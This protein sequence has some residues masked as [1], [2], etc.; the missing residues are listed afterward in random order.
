MSSNVDHIGMR[1]KDITSKFGR[2][3]RRRRQELGFSQERLAELADLLRTYIADIER[4]TRNLSLINI[5]K[6]SRALDLKPAELFEEY[7]EK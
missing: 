5:I 2:G 4:G 6:L 7:Y 3:I 1:E